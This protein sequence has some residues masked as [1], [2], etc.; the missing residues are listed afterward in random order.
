MTIFLQKS[1]GGL[2]L[3]LVAMTLTS[4]GS[5]PETSELAEVVGGST[6]T[7]T[8]DE[9]IANG[10]FQL[11]VSV[12][13]H[14]YKYSMDAKKHGLEPMFFPKGN[15]FVDV[16]GKSNMGTTIAAIKALAVGKSADLKLEWIDSD[17]NANHIYFTVHK[18]PAD[19]KGI[20]E[21]HFV[22]TELRLSVPFAFDYYATKAPHKINGKRKDYGDYTIWMGALIDKNGKMTTFHLPGVF[23]QAIYEFSR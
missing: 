18:K 13:A 1:I 15:Q 10:I 5:E 7:Q 6:V 12:N 21:V 14:K 23:H 8:D 9:I 3:V 4:C 22:L 16:K 17:D 19:I 2:F 11:L 20:S